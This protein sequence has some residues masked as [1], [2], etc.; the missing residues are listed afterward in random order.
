[1]QAMS[2]EHRGQ[3]SDQ[4][5]KPKHRG[6]STTSLVLCLDLLQAQGPD[7]TNRAVHPE[8][9]G[10]TPVFGSEVPLFKV[11]SQSVSKD[12]EFNYPMRG[13]TDE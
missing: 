11:G 5:L 8:K 9:I 3:R 13:E 4:Q 7:F 10:N 6:V 2:P 1:M 12:R